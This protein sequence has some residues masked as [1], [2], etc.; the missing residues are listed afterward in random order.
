M[1]GM[2]ATVVEGPVDGD[3]DGRRECPQCV[4]GGLLGSSS[5]LTGDGHFQLLGNG[6]FLAPHFADLPPNA[7]ARQ[8]PTRPR[9]DYWI[10][11]SS[12]TSPAARTGSS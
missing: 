8:M 7:P 1:E 5:L 6:S 10:E 2:E 9:P 11:G 12:L 4:V 3:R